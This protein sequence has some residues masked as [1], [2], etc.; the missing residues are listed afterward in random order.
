MS[1]IVSG[2]K[3]DVAAQ[4]GNALA[5][6]KEVVV[7]T[8]D[9]SGSMG[10]GMSV[11]H[12]SGSRSEAVCQAVEAIISVSNPA[13]TK[14]GIVGFE[15]RSYVVVEPTDR[16][17]SILGNNQPIAAGGTDMAGGIILAISL[18]PHRLILLSDG[19]PN[20][21]DAALSA[22]KQAASCKIKIDTISVGAAND[23]LLQEI[24]KMTGGVWQRCDSVND[25][26]DHF[27]QL[28]TEARLQLEHK[29]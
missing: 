22:A 15:S 11:M 4:R 14:Y 8:L 18:H 17:L 21:E 28:E 19:E 13:L 2:T 27:M 1:N 20:S 26:A 9:H 3:S 25:L 24:A 23:A 16:F 12:D 10:S 5:T 6:Q 7:L 29:S